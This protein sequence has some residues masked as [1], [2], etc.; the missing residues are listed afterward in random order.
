M[1]LQLSSIPELQDGFDA[2]GFSQGKVSIPVSGLPDFD[3]SSKGGLFLRAY[4]ERLDS[5]ADEQKRTPSYSN[6]TISSSSIDKF[7][8]QVEQTATGTVFR[9]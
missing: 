2:M 8:S 7:L 5:T 6:D 1:S 9:A 3:S 4:V